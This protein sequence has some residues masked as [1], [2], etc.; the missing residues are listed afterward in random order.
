MKEKIVSIFL[1][2]LKCISVFGTSRPIIGVLAQEFGG[3]KA[4]SFLT[5]KGSTYIAASYIKAVESSG[6]RVVPIFV[7]RSPQYYERILN[8]L[9]GVLVPGGATKI[10][11]GHPF[12]D[13][14]TTIVR[15]S[16]KM[17]QRGIYFPIL[18]VCWGFE[19]MVTLYNGH[20]DLQTH[21]NVIRENYPLKFE[22]KFTESL[23][24]S[25]IDHQTY[26]NLKYFPTTVNAHYWCTTQRNFTRSHLDKTWK[27]TST[28][29]SSRGL[30]FIATIEHKKYPFIAV[31]FHPERAIFEWDD[32]LN[33]VHH[34]AAVQANRYFY[35]VLVKLS[36]LNSN[37]FRTEKEE[38]DA[39]IYNY[40]P[41]CP[42][43]KPSVFTQIYVFD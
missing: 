7:N 30:K 12:Y 15:I 17:N 25:R 11:P 22:P 19:A 33:I 37:K 32:T 34:S 38:R 42:D 13:A 43:S 31:Q 24:F 2:L 1:V 36:K 10:E 39:L 14:F 8:S 21:C 9:N 18:S 20:K 35:D 16:E 28:S 23:L 29:V 4:G 41:E 26:I 3:F 5:D 27:I 6:A 40:K